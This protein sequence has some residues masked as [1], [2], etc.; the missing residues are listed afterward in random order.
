MMGG[1]CM[2]GNC[3]GFGMVFGWIFWLLILAGVIYAVIWFVRQL[4]SQSPSSAQSSDGTL[5]Q[6]SETPLTILKR[7][8]AAGEIDQ[9]QFE[10]MKNQ[11]V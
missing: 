11:L 4:G 6:T 5:T 7:R 9:T 2:G 1:N 10:T 3:M 8:Y